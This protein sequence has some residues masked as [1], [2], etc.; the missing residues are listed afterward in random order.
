METKSCICIEVKKNDL[1]FSFFMPGNATYG[2]AY[3]AAFEV[4]AQISS[5]AQQAIEKSKPQKEDS[6]AP[7]EVG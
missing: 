2:M 5:L 6:D 3:D 4:L 7:T 1:T